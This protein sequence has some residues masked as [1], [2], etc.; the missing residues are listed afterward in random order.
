M[1]E[2]EI[3]QLVQRMGTAFEDFKSRHDATLDKAVKRLDEFEKKQNRLS[4]SG[5]LDISSGDAV[6]E[7][8]AVSSLIRAARAGGAPMAASAYPEIKAMSTGSD[9]G[10][11]YVVLPEISKQMTTK[12][13]DQSAVRRLARVVQI[14]SDSWEEVVDANDVTATWTGER[15]A[16][17][18]TGTADLGKLSVPV[19][20]IYANQPITQNLLDDASIDV[21]AWAVG[22]AND[23]FGRSEGGAF[24]NG[25][26][27]AKPR[28]FLTYTNVTTSDATREQGQ[29]QYIKTGAA[30]AFAASNPA[31]KLIDMVYT[32]RAPYKQG[33]GVA[34]LMNS[35]TAGTVRKFK[36]GQGQYLWQDAIA[37]GQPP[38]LLGYPVELDESMPDLGADAYPIA[39]GNWQLGYVIVDRIGL[40]LLVDPS[41]NKPY[42]MFY[43]TKRVGGGLANSE[44]I[45]LLKCEA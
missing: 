25:D 32:L 3:A 8:K 33:A 28:G 29:L 2:S 43:A 41:T 27:V 30:A 6:A 14:S 12:L 24:I 13:F 7:T 16:R 37:K 36:D 39:F 10:G 22:K 26:G 44:A 4:L 23:K 35:T 42:V 45:K 21:G 5:A 1:D 19:K 17:P 20:E 31:D 38:S 40:R 15:S 18:E 11:G 9:P 34:W